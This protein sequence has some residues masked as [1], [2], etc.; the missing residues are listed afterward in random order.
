MDLRRL[1][2][3]C[4][5]AEELHFGRAAERMH[6]VQSAVSQQV[7]CLEEELGF[8]LLDRSRH[9]VRLT[10]QG[11]VFLPEARAILSRMEAGIQRVRASADGIVGRLAIG[12]VDNVLWSTLPPM[13]REFRSRRPMVELVLRPL[14]RAVQIDALR[15]SSIDVGILPAPAPGKGVETSLLVGAPLLAALPEGHRFA[16]QPSLSLAAL[17]DE[18]FV[19]FPPTMRSRILELITAACAQAGF[20]PRIAQE[21]EQ[22][23]TLMALVN[24][25]LGVTLV[26]DWVARAH[27]MGIRY[28]RIEDALP[29]YELLVAWRTGATNPA[30][31]AFRAIAEGAA[32]RM[33]HSAME[34]TLGGYECPRSPAI[35]DRDHDFTIPRWTVHRM[36]PIVSGTERQI[37]SHK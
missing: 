28:A 18:P 37:R 25:G 1:R 7:K 35:T 33:G 23:H 27:P 12:F 10:I 14:D 16:G 2:Y 36:P 8:D 4:A 9:G 32:A 13:L 22:L 5:V 30:I 34:T 3:F 19:L 15:A 21:A 20:T 31:E 11:T 6:V 29:P 24:A 17:A 26:P